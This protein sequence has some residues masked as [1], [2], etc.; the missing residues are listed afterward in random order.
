LAAKHFTVKDSLDKDEYQSVEFSTP[1][2]LPEIIN[3]IFLFLFGK[4]PFDH[5]SNKDAYH[6]QIERAVLD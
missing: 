4:L 1:N 5:Q 2:G 6:R 3:D